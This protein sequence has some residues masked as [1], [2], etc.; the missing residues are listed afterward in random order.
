VLKLIGAQN[1]FLGVHKIL[2]S[3]N[4]RAQN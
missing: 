4:L 1:L 3:K 2:G